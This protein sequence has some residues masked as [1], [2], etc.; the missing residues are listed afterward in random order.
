M[1]GE[2]I[3]YHIINCTISGNLRE[4]LI[5]G[6][7]DEFIQVRVGA[8]GKWFLKGASPLEDVGYH[9]LAPSLKIMGRVLEWEVTVF[10][11][12]FG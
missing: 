2:R 9:S 12:R 8:D 3:A 5:P 1:G 6:I 4:F 7:L 10:E 11:V